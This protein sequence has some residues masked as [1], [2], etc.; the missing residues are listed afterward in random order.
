[1]IEHKPLKENQKDTRTKILN[2]AL[3]LFNEYGYDETTI[4][5]I[6]Q[7]AGVSKTTLHYYFPKKQDLFVDMYND[8]E[9]LYSDNF[10]RIVEQETFSKQ[11]WEVFHIM[12]EGDLF[13]GASVSQQYFI[14]RLKE[15]SQQ[16]FIKNIYHKKMLTAVIRSAQ[17]SNQIRNQTDPEVLAEVGWGGGGGVCV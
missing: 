1:M 9:E 16:D 13:Y 8:F 7:K 5:M 2:S 17:N 6:C 14:N 15:H 3:E 4:P 11:I 12:C 10:Y